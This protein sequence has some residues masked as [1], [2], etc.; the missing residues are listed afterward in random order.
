ML[1][2]YLTL[3]CSV[4]A[5]FS[6]CM[7]DSSRPAGPQS[8]YRTEAVAHD[9]TGVHDKKGLLQREIDSGARTHSFTYNTLQDLT[10]EGHPDFGTGITYTLDVNRNRTKR[11]VNGVQTY[12]GYD[13]Q[14]KLLWLNQGTNAAPTTGQTNPYRLY[15]YDSGGFPTKIE[16]RDV[17]GQAVKTELYDFD[18]AAKLRQIRD[19]ATG[20]VLYSATNDGSGAR[21][22]QTQ[23]GVRHNSTM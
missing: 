11:A 9:G 21:V 19:N 4:R 22:T 17:T 7:P 3:A 18:G 20:T 5:L 10:S 23:G 6:T 8:C 16:H 14:N 2:V 12:A 13:G 1:L 15:W